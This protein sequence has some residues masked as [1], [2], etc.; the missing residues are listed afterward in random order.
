MSLP[1]SFSQQG[2]G[3]KMRGFNSTL[4]FVDDLLDMSENA[5]DA[6]R[7]NLRA[8]AFALLKKLSFN[9]QG[10]CKGMM[11]NRR[12]NDIEPSMFA[13]DKK[14]ELF[15]C[16]DYLGDI[17]QHN[18]KNSE[19]VKDRLK[20]GL[21]V[22][23]K[24]ETI[25]S[26]TSFGKHTIEVS[27]LLYRALFLSSILFNSQG[28]RNL[29]KTDID[30][31]QSLQLRLLKK[32]VGAPSSISNP[33]L[34]L[35]LGV[36]PIKYE[37]HKRQISFLHHIVN[38]CE[39]DPVRML[40]ENMKRLPFEKNWLNDVLASASEYSIDVDEE[41]LQS[42]SK[43]TF[44]SK[45]RSAIETHAFQ[46]LKIECSA[47]TKTKYLQYKVFQRQPYLVQLYPSQAK[48]ILQC[49]A[50]CLKIKDHRPFQFKNN[51]C[52]WCNLEEETVNHIV[53]C[54]CDEEM[55]PVC[56]NDIDKIDQ[57]LECKLTTFATRINHFL[58]MVDY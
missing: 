52:R 11:V 41:R 26:E 50:K 5:T 10:K 29:T 54:G 49:R 6:E 24:I 18:G 34:F 37:I 25:M 42:I 22:M 8:L 39:D 43:D 28:W 9:S 58:D 3:D 33:F 46:K 21:K 55:T 4:A 1:V 27:L 17:F 32:L 16:V 38:L 36:L 14:I 2:R 12:V 15:S 47:Q 23:L 45:V 57:L 13:R 20:R 51:I 35:E 31:L 48:V 19:L 30:Q 44:K 56:I 40:Y 53:N 7:A